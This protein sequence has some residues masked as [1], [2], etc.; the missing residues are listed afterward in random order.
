[1]HVIKPRFIFNEETSFQD[2]IEGSVSKATVLSRR[3]GALS[4]QGLNQG[5][6]VSPYN[7]MAIILP[8]EPCGRIRDTTPRH[9]WRDLRVCMAGS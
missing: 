7:L 1:M 3:E 6:V 5:R 8:N 9:L 4:D 2:D